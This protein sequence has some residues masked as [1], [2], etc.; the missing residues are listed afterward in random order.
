MSKPVELKYGVPQGSVLGPILFTLYTSPLG[1][2]CRKYGVKYHCYADDKQNYLSFKPNI[3]GNQEECIRNLELCIAEIRKWMQ[4][5]LLKLND[6]KTEFLLVGTKQQLNK[7]T[8]IN[9]KISH[10]EIKPVS[11]IRNLGYHQDAEM[12]N[13]EHVNKLCRQLYPILKRIAKVR[14]SLT[15][16]ATKILIQSLVLGRIDY[17]NFNNYKTCPAE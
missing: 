12:K 13:A 5:N 9:V 3:K 4:T 11:S 17:C 7:I 15:K 10:D 8:N 2:I 14:Q 6:E 16:E 1:D